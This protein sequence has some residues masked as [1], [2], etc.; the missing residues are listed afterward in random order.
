MPARL[1]ESS[2]LIPPGWRTVYVVAHK[3][4]AK[5][6]LRVSP[7]E[8]W[9]ALALIA[10]C[11]LVPTIGI[12]AV[13]AA[14]T[15]PDLSDLTPIADP[16]GYSLL[17]WPTLLRDRAHTLHAESPVYAGAA[18]RALGYMMDGDRPARTNEPVSDFVLLP[19]A[20]NPLHPAHRFGDQMI[21]VHLNSAARVRFSAGALVWVWG[22][23]RFLPGDPAGALPLYAL[24]AFR[25]EPAQT[26]EI[27]RYFK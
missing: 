24:E 25:V 1:P 8:Q 11:T 14:T 5:K 15:R 18:V 7:A 4:G 27:A 23:L 2:W 20:G 10:T 17:S 16:A 3:S 22:T 13:I 9:R 19:D 26:E 6:R 21:A 12:V